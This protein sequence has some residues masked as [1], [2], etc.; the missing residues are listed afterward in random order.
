MLVIPYG[1]GDYKTLKT[2]KAFYADRTNY[3]ELLEFRLTKRLLFLRPRRF[4]KSLFLSTLHYYY[5]L[6]H[7]DDFDMLFGNTYIGKNPTPLAN[8]YLILRFNFSSI[9]TNNP[10]DTYADFLFIIQQSIEEFLNTYRMIF[11]RKLTS[12]K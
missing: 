7:K 1:T 8:K 12:K 11:L 10:E 3:I 5:G 2:D 6:E 9:R 4:G